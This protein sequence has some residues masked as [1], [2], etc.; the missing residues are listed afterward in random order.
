MNLDEIQSIWD[1]ESNFQP[2]I[3]ANQWRSW[4]EQR[5]QKLRWMIGVVEIVMIL[6]LLFVAAMFFRDPI[7]DGHDYVLIAPGILA[8]A[9]AAFVWSGRIA[10]RKRDVQYSDSLLSIVQQSID[11][12]D[13]QKWWMQSFVWWFAAPMF[14]GLLIGLAIVDDS[15]RYLFYWVFIPA[16]LICMALTI[17]QIRREIALKILPERNRLEQFRQQLAVDESEAS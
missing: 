2:S 17:W 3:D 4:I 8:L 7:I 13:Y 11:A 15:K 10:R 14:I 6:T 9:A 16:F 12:L 5:N 1:S